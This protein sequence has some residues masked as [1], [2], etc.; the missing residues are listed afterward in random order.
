[1]SGAWES[2]VPFDGSTDFAGGSGSNSVSAGAASGSGVTQ[3][4]AIHD[5][6][7]CILLTPDRR[8]ITDENNQYINTG[9]LSL[10]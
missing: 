2:I 10:G 7:I 3:S 9:S 4:I 6:S 5:T 8:I 1:M